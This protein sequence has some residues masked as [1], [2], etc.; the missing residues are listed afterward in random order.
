M[1]IWKFSALIVLTTFLMG[2]S[3]AVGKIG[4]H[5]A[6]PLFLAGLRFVLA[7]IIMVV[8]WYCED[9][10]LKVVPFGLKWG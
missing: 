10:I 5:Y 6:S 9:L 8:C 1:N 3:F 7:G 4:L 2:S